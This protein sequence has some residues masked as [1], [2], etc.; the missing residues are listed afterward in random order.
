M[1]S[2]GKSTNEQTGS[3]DCSECSFFYNFSKHCDFPVLGVILGTY[4]SIFI[5]NPILVNLKVNY[6]TIVKEEN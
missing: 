6:K 3:K 1:T 4:S 2:Q 5:A